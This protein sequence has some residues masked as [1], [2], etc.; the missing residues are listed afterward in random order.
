ML[1]GFFL[2]FVFIFYNLQMFSKEAQISLNTSNYYSINRD[3]LLLLSYTAE[4]S[5][6]LNSGKVKIEIKNTTKDTLKVLFEPNAKLK[7]DLFEFKNLR[8]AI[9]VETNISIKNKKTSR[10]YVFDNNNVQM[11]NNC[12]SII[13]DNI[14][15]EYLKIKYNMNIIDERLFYQ[16]LFTLAP[17]SVYSI[18]IKFKHC[19]K[20]PSFCLIFRYQI[21][22]NFTRN[23]Q[24]D[25]EN[26]KT[27]MICIPVQNI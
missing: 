12:N 23:V 14:Y 5:K 3:S 25:F 20:I 19:E 11:A 7:H 17:Q 4:F 10:R 21:I 2:F 26:L 18:K 24:F 1:K 13:D 9:Y 8:Q 6:K 27:Q 15:G 22:G 16:D